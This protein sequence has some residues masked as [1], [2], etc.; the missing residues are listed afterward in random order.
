MLRTKLGA[1]LKSLPV[2]D[3]LL[4]GLNHSYAYVENDPLNLIDPLGLYGTTDCSYYQ[5]RCEQL[6]GV[7]YCY[8]APTVCENTPPGP[9]ANCVRQCLQEFDQGY[10]ATDNCGGGSDVPCVVNIH[11]MCWQEC[12]G[13]GP[14]ATYP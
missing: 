14:L 12:I 13:G 8:L 7:Y 11:Q 1:Y 2:Q 4:R 3:V 9:W 5:Q 6:G 10:C